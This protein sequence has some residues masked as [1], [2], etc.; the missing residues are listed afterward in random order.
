MPHRDKDGNSSHVGPRGYAAEQREKQRK[1]AEK[2]KK[3]TPKP[4]PKKDK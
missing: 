4:K 3:A 2:A 1:E